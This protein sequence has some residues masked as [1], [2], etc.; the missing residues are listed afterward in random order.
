[1]IKQGSRIPLYKSIRFRVS[2]ILGLMSLLTIPSLYWIQVISSEQKIQAEAETILKDKA[3]PLLTIFEREYRSKTGSSAQYVMGSMSVDANLLLSLVIDKKGDVLMSSKNI[4]I[5]KT[6]TKDLLSEM[7]PFSESEMDSLLSFKI[8]S[9]QAQ[10]LLNSTKKIMLFVSPVKLYRDDSNFGQLVLFYNFERFRENKLQLLKTQNYIFLG[11][12]LILSLLLFFIMNYMVAAPALQLMTQL[13]KQQGTTLKKVQIPQS[14]YEI[15]MIG[16][17][18]NKLIEDVNMTQDE[19]QKA[20][21]VAENSSRMKS[22]FLAN[23]SHEIRTPLNSIVGMIEVLQ[24]TPLTAE[25]REYVSLFKRASSALLSIV[26]DI[27]D[28]SKIEAGAVELNIESFLLKDVVQDVIQTLSPLAKQKNI[29]LEFK[30]SP[31]MSSSY[32]GDVA[33]IRQILTNLISNSLKFTS[34]GFVSLSIQPNSTGK[35][36]NL[37]FTVEDTGIGISKEKIGS[38]F[39]IFTQADS[40]ITKTYGGTGL[41]LAL[42]KKL[43]EMMGGEIWLESTVGKGSC[44]YFTLD[45]LEVTEHETKDHLQISAQ[46]IST[47]EIKPLKILLVDDSIENRVLIKTFLKKTNHQITEAENGYEAVQLARDNQFDVILMDLQ[48]PVMDGLKATQMIRSFEKT[49]HKERV[50]IIALTAYALKEEVD[51]SIAS[52]CDLHLSK[53]IK[54]STLIEVLNSISSK[55]IKNQA[56]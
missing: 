22:E 16:E 14:S 35:S 19:V 20:K 56:A 5:G 38:L 33:K 43:T 11:F 47:D 26:N 3:T 7:K 24:E 31:N 49:N 45:L 53:P 1:M 55:L 34:E 37:F 27:L 44:F 42:C 30:I 21:E 6:F 25:Q 10:L 15:Y 50:H 17:V 46:T 52:G 41:G 13:L 8:D 48:M 40:S 54:K 23:M 51:K 28:M 12:F 32:K 29:N 2:V 4:L 18:F 36:G 9:M 39:R